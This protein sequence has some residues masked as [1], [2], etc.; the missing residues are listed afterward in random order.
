LSPRTR[1]ALK[2]ADEVWIATALLHRENPKRADFTVAEIVERARQEKLS[3]ALR[4]GVYVHAVQHCVANRPPNPGRYR[5]LLATG[6]NRRRLFRPGDAYHPAREGAKVAPVREDIPAK[7]HELVDWYSKDYARRGARRI[8][9][10]PL[11]GLRG[12]GRTLW[13]N[14]H[15]DDYVRRLR[16]GWE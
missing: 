14:E 10:D 13:A 1:G 8:G 7:Y 6:E 3:P 15:A 9:T 4:P 2:V 12:S 5:M 11:L 16:E